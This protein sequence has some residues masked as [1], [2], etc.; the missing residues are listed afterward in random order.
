M[1]VIHLNWES[2]LKAGMPNWKQAV[3]DDNVP[4]KLSLESF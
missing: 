3:K 1:S 2:L 4:D